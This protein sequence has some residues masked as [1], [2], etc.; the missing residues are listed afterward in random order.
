MRKVTNPKKTVT[1]MY[2][3]DV[4][5]RFSR[6]DV[7]VT[8]TALDI[9]GDE[10]SGESKSVATKIR[11]YNKDRTRLDAALAELFAAAEE[12]GDEEN[13]WDLTTQ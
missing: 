12:I 9:D 5:T 10:V 6:G 8:L 7:I 13:W 4:R 11:P 3:S 2:V 1:D